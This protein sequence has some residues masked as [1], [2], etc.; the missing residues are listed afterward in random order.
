M[1]IALETK[2]ALENSSP[3]LD[4]TNTR[5]GAAR[6]RELNKILKEAPFRTPLNL[7]ERQSGLWSIKAEEL[8]IGVSVPLISRR[9]SFLTGAPILHI[10]LSNPLR[11]HKLMHDGDLITSDIPQEVYTQSLSFKKAHGC[12]LVGGLGI[13][14]AAVMIA[15][16]S[17]VEE[18][19]VVELVP[20]VIKMMH[21]Q[22]PKTKAPISIVQADL[23]SYLKEWD[24]PDFDFAYFD[25]WSPTGEGSW[26]DYIVPL[27]R[28]IRK[29]HG[30]KP[31][32]CWLESEMKGQ[33]RSSFHAMLH[34]VEDTNPTGWI[35]SFRPLWVFSQAIQG[36]T[37]QDE[38]DR[39][40]DL[41]L[42]KI[43]SP[44][45]EK[46]FPWDQ[47]KEKKQ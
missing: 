6:M 20:E 32:E 35:N 18:V 29:H 19:R 41:Y 2:S 23:F 45:W 5:S 12:V 42:N 15:N 3:M 14:M 25:I 16:M 34:P 21:G 8:Q 22:L 39:L 4:S 37:R 46:T 13:G 47:F 30:N 27:R 28:L 31:V 43:G 44:K 36:I 38:I 24:C 11:V 9:T 10:K 7:E 26:N 17:D 40:I 33:M 1:G